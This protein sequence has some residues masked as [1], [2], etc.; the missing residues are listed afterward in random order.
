M[1]VRTDEMQPETFRASQDWRSEKLEADSIVDSQSGQKKLH[2]F[3]AHEQNCLFLNRSGKEFADLSLLSGLDNIADGRTFVYWDYDRDG[4]QDIALVNANSPLLN[5]YRNS[6]GQL[7]RDGSNAG[8]IIAVRYVGANRAAA[9]S[10]GAACRDGYGAKVT[11]DLGP[12]TLKREHRCGEGFCAQNSAT[13]IIGVGNHDAAR[14]LT[15]RWP[16]GKSQTIE[17][18][19]PGT[20]LTAYENAEESADGSG[21][22][23]APYRGPVGPDAQPIADRRAF[24][25]GPTISLLPAPSSPPDSKAT[26][27]LRMYTTMATW[28]A[29]CQRHLPQFEVLRSAFPDDDL[30]IYGVPVDARDTPAML[31]KYASTFEPSYRL[32]INLTPQQR[33]RVLAV[34]TEDLGSE[35]LPSTIVTDAQGQV[36]QSLPG[37]PTVSDVRKWTRRQRPDAE[38]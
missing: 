14:S 24:R 37:L 7:A 9:P 6:I 33:S 11:V 4:W 1:V 25:P 35:A 20:Q 12:L 28:C 18:V 31:R 23:A 34:L 19:L 3:S 32:L 17:N 29:A 36:L 15:V 2:S 26:R 21:F 5:F 27:A 22:D 10:P 16:S 30:E 13:M 8:H 38:L